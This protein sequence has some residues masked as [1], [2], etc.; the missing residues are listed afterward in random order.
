MFLAL[1]TEPGGTDL[2]H[3]S[4]RLDRAAHVHLQPALMDSIGGDEANL[5]ADGWQCACHHV[6]GVRN[7]WS[8]CGQFGVFSSEQ[9]TVLLMHRL[10]CVHRRN[11]P[12]PHAVLD[13][14]NVVASVPTSSQ[15]TS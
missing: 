15:L 11:Q 9:T 3:M 7:T 14:A 1:P 4:C 5:V 13:A 6:R 12:R 2:L 8:T 10:R